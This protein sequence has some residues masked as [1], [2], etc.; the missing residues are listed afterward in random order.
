M[1]DREGED[2][3]KEQV[4]AGIRSRIEAGEWAPRRRLPTI[5][6]LAFEYGVA[7]TTMQLALQHLES[8]GVIY[9]VRNRG[10]FVKLG[11]DNVTVTTLTE[12]DRSIS[13]PAS[14]REV[15][16]LALSEGGWVTVV[17]RA[18]G[19]IEVY[20]ADKVEIRGEASN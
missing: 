14:E 11:A 20:P 7:K 1:V 5:V 4:A 3:V 17:E 16:D 15:K 18:D 9:I 10:A 19:E 12:G 13:R 6:D 8:L 2:T